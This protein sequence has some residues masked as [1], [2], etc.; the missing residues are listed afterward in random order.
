MQARS[1]KI[2]EEEVRC[3]Q[4]AEAAQHDLDEALPALAEAV[5]ALE[6]LNKKDIG[7]IKSYGRPPVLVEKCMEAVMILKG[8][9]PTWAEAKRQLGK[10]CSSS[11]SPLS[12]P[13]SFG[14]ERLQLHCVMNNIN[15][16]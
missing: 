11:N 2:G 14:S 3:K 1:E 10:N 16:T 9:E 15:P 4:M 13:V 7:E 5:K 12:P 8:H 6:A